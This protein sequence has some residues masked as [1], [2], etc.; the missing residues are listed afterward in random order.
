MLLSELTY[1]KVTIPMQEK[2]NRVFYNFIRMKILTDLVKIVT[3]KFDFYFLVKMALSI[4]FPPKEQN[5]TLKLHFL[6]RVL[7]SIVG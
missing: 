7:A 2:K 3:L 5:S 6:F 1:I 4:F